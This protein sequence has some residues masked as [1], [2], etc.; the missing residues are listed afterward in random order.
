MIYRIW[1]QHGETDYLGNPI[2]SVSMES[3]DLEAIKREYY[4]LNVNG[5][6]P[7]V[8]VGVM[9]WE[10]LDMSSQY[11]SYELEYLAEDFA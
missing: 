10:S 7:F 3:E 4:R 9:R 8:E 6:E 2:R 11:K 1:A 5:F